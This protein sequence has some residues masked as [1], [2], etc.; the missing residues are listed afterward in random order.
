MKIIYL[1]LLLSTSALAQD[2]E[3]FFQGHTYTFSSNSELTLKSERLNLS[4]NKQACSQQLRDLLSS[5]FKSWLKTRII[6]PRE[7]KSLIQI[8]EN[9]KMF[10]VSSFTKEGK[11]LLLFPDWFAKSKLTQKKLCSNPKK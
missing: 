9:G 5:S 3:V 11:Q 6:K 4:I 8:K 2:Y 10:Y 7:T 1:I